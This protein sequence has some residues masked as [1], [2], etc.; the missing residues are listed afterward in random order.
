MPTVTKFAN[1]NAAVTTGWS[2]PTNAYADD[3]VY[4][5]AAPGKNADITT[6]Y[7]FPAFTT[8]DIPAGSVINSVTV[9]IQDKSSTTS[10]TGATIGVQLENN[11]T[12]LGSEQTQGMSTT[13]QLLTHQV[14]TGIAQADLQTANVVKARVRGHRANSNNAITWS[15][16][17]VKLTIDYS[18]GAQSGSPASAVSTWVALAAAVTLG[19]VARTPASAQSVWT[20][21]TVTRS[22][23]ITRSPTASSAAW[24]ALNA[25]ASTGA[26]SQNV[27][28]SSATSN[29]TA[30]SGTP[31]AG[32]VSQAP[33]S[34]ATAWSALAATRTAGS[35]QVSPLVSPSAW[36]APSAVASPGQ[37]IVA[38]G[39]APNTWVVLS[40]TGSSGPASVIAAPATAAFA[41]TDAA[42]VPGLATGTPSAAASGW[43]ALD[44][45]ATGAGSPRRP[46]PAIATWAAL[47]A[48][49][50]AGSVAVSPQSSTAGWS[51][52]P[53]TATAGSVLVA[54]SAAASRWSALD[55]TPG[56]GAP[57]TQH[58]ITATLNAEPRSGSAILIATRA[59]A[60]VTAFPRV[61]ASL[62]ANGTPMSTICH[63]RVGASNVISVSNL[64]DQLDPA[65]VF[66]SIVCTVEILN[67]NGTQFMAPA[68][69]D[70][71]QAGDTWT[72]TLAPI[73]APFEVDRIYTAKIVATM[74]DASNNAVTYREEITLVGTEQ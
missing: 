71:N 21:P 40:A 46:S 31:T 9:E 50:A 48:A 5:T 24:T 26:P 49:R 37:A 43:T 22:A 8:S 54:P 69:M 47:D 60:E 62:A 14:T 74:Q 58:Q 19:A 36:T 68:T 25:S 12:L 52:L 15:L 3:G 1:A 30:L 4:A 34:A 10:S 59:D 2:S 44:A 20:A 38:P 66:T 41:A 55:A 13:D 65:T 29:W 11:T 16:D 6:D 63:V 73:D 67:R 27:T 35:I 45:Q 18:P 51:A 56:T 53:A 61:V 70:A 39:A 32:A 57:P 23:T 42:S 7:G 64:V 72:V 17:Y 28:A 33:A